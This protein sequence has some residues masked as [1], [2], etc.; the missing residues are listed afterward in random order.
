VIV[1]IG[2]LASRVAKEH[3]G[4][5]TL[6]FSMVYTP[7]RFSLGDERITGVPL[8]VP[9]AEVFPHIRRLFPSVRRIGMLSDP[10]K[11][12]KIAEQA[13]AEAKE[14]G[15][16]LV[17]AKV[18]SEQSLPRAMRSLIGKI[19]LLWL[20]PDRMVITPQSVDF[21]LGTSF[22]ANLPVVT[23]TE[24]LVKR[25][26]VAA[27]SPDYQAVG[28]EAARLALRVLAGESPLNYSKIPQKWKYKI[29]LKYDCF[30]DLIRL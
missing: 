29:I 22:E 7:E 27:L 9:L 17:V 13:K 28:E 3:L 4:H 30:C 10:Q 26:A 12:G 19:D 5:T 8:D 20:V 15:F 1:T 14:R 16:S 2:L 24:D 11:T 6:V 18:A 21:H 23:F 25:A